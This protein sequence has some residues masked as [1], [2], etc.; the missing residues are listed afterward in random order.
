IKGLRAEAWDFDN[1][2][3]LKSHEFDLCDFDGFEAVPDMERAI[4][5]RRFDGV[6]L[7]PLDMAGSP[8]G[9][10]IQIPFGGPIGAGKV[11]QV[12]VTCEGDT[13]SAQLLEGTPGTTTNEP[14]GGG[15]G[16]ETSGDGTSGTGGGADSSTG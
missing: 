7:Q 8:V 14:T 15:T 11:A 13:C 6:V 10:S 2:D 12:S 4:N 9:T 3:Q 5:G 1:S 16:D